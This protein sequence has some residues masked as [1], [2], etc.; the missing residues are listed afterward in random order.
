M[1]IVSV[2]TVGK[3]MK[4][5]FDDQ[6]SE[7]VQYYID[8]V[9]SYIE[10]ETG[11]SFVKIVGDVIREEADE[12][13][14]ISLTQEPIH[15]IQSVVDFQTTIELLPQTQYFWNGI[16]TIR[17]LYPFQVVDITLDY[18]YDPCP[19][20]IQGVVVEAIR[21]GLATGNLPVKQ[22]TVGDVTVIYGDLLTFSKSDLEII[23]R[24]GSTETTWGPSEPDRYETHF[25]PFDGGFTTNGP[26]NECL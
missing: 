7:Q 1:G 13:G 12:A 9:S 8:V 10:T 5:T 6:Q 24:Y 17:G 26:G 19:M 3:A 11:C 2:S 22:T 14:R 21:R 16:N 25:Y 23:G 20:D 18:G 4:K 15:D